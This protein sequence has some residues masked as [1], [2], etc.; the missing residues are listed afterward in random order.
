MCFISFLAFS[1]KRIIDFFKI[2]KSADGKKKCT[3]NQGKKNVVTIFCYIYLGLLV[4][5][6]EFLFIWEWP[7]IFEAH[8]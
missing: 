8:S 3:L 1:Q 2:Q 4:F 7:T 5:R 6:V